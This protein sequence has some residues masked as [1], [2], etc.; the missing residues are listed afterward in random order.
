MS[1][2]GASHAVEQR[3]LEK[4]GLS[5][6]ALSG[7]VVGIL[8]V[9]FL[10]IPA[11][12]ID[13]GLASSF[14]LSIVILM[15]SLWIRKPIE[16]SS[17]PTLLLIATLLR[18]ALN[19]ATT[20]LIL[21]HGAEGTSAAGAIIGAFASLV[22]GNDFVIGLIVFAIL[23]VINF[24]VITKGATRI[25]EVGARFTLDAIPGKQMAIDADLSAGLIDDKQAQ[26]RRREL[27]EES[28][29]FGAMDGASKFVR[30]DAI[31][32]LIILA[33]NI[34]GGIVTGMLRHDLG[35]V[36]AADVYIKLSVGDGLVTQIPA[37]IVSLAAGLLVSKGGTHLSA[38]SA[39]FGQ[40]GEHPRSLQVTAGLLIVLGMM[41]GFPLFPFLL[42]G[43]ALVAT[44]RS[45]QVSHLAKAQFAVGA[46]ESPPPSETQVIS[47]QIKT[48]PI[49][50]VM[51]NQTANWIFGQRD[52]MSF[53][54][55]QA[56]KRFAHEIGFIIPEVKLSDSEKLPVR[57]YQIRVHGSIVGQF[58]LRINEALIIYGDGP[59][60]NYP[61]DEVADP[62]YGMA[63][64]WVPVQ[65]SD[66]LRREGFRAV[67]NLSIVLTHLSESIRSNLAQL[68]SYRDLRAII[69]LQ[70]AE[71]RKLLDEICPSQ[72]SLSGIQGIL[73]GLLVE[74]VSLRPFGLILEAIAEVAPHVRR[75]ERIV[76][77]VRTRIGPQICS[78]YLENGVLKVL[79][80]SPR[81]EST[82]QSGVRKDERGDVVQFNA[83]PA[84]LETFR[85]EVIKMVAASRSE[86]ISKIAIVAS[87]E[88]RPYV[89]M[90]LDR[91]A[92]NIPVLSHLEISRGVRIAAIGTI[93]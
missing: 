81:W 83:D 56:R 49:E 8:L 27:E 71:Y 2:T 11:F 32:G 44:A 30:G 48:S 72:I 14:A 21:S 28:A 64:M 38:Q 51:G 1:L 19:I 36:Q 33:V 53:R 74:R 63:A 61:G 92:P 84:V 29:F 10:P 9:I 80:L 58:E 75:L 52:E 16:L 69:D 22:M 55:N 24:V 73:K 25:A 60:P 76:E 40:I 46:L 34:F 23:V 79:Y 68:F 18:L 42:L 6:I 91:A 85:S 35:F 86:N 43:G 12:I 31:A 57:S 4:K 45:V 78:D 17:F 50:L 13:F 5:E 77:H 39:I 67:D 90:I 59:K 7:G 3:T 20:R 37:L 82:I 62:A 66:D 88:I 26:Q 93:Q 54:V 65:L 89:N 87:G 15:L 47:D 41:P 70:D